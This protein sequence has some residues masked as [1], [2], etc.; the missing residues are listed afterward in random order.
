[1]DNC[2]FT[3]LTLV[4]AGLIG[5]PVPNQLVYEALEPSCQTK[6][7]STAMS[8]RPIQVSSLMR[9]VTRSSSVESVMVARSALS[10]PHAVIASSKVAVSEET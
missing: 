5:L 10:A 9:P 4:L 3:Q 6:V 7:S 8:F 2:F 1:M